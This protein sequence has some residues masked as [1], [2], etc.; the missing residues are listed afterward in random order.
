MELKELQDLLQVP[1]SYINKYINFKQKVLEV[2]KREINKYSDLEIDF[3]P[4]KRGRAVYWIEFTIKR[5]AKNIIEAKA[6]E[7][8]LKNEDIK[9][10]EKFKVL[11]LK[12]KFDENEFEDEFEQFKVYNDNKID[13][14]TQDN[15]KKWCMQKKRKAMQKNNEN[16][17]SQEQNQYRWNFKKAKAVSD[18]IKDWL[19]FELAIDWISEYYYKDIYEFE[20]DDKKIGIQKV[21]HSDFNK[22]EYILFFVEDEENRYLLEN[23]DTV[24][25]LN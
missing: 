10:F 17:A 16:A 21:M 4:I 12:F 19:E 8:I 9:E 6:Q 2:A 14:I 23:K 22:E 13:K 24:I 20:I 7:N 5:N 18:K 3:T 25:E 15:F 1:Q 11:F